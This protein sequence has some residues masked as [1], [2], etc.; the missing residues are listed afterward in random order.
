MAVFGGSA[1]WRRRGMKNGGDEGL[2][3]HE[4]GLQSGRSARP[5][6]DPVASTALERAEAD[7]L[8]D[9]VHSAQIS[10][11]MS[12]LSACRPLAVLVAAQEP[13]T[14]RHVVRL[15]GETHDAV[16]VGVVRDE[17]ATIDEVGRLR[18][19][20]VIVES[21]PP[22]CGGLRIAARL[23]Q[24]AGPD[25]IVVSGA[26]CYAAS[27]FDVAVLDYLL[28]PLR[29]DRLRRALHRARCRRTE[30]DSHR[31]ALLA[32]GAMRGDKTIHVPDRQ[33]GRNVCIGD[34]VWIQAERDY[35]LIHAVSRTHMLRTTMAA[36]AARLSPAIIRVHRSAFVSAR[37]VRRW[38]APAKG[39]HGLQLSN[40][41]E[42]VVGPTY[43]AAVRLALRSLDR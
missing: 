12:R 42:V 43:I 20:V 17:G 36:L 8:D 2:A 9:A 4:C 15:I 7:L 26:G 31:I 14:A 34:I 11:L 24:G 35:A 21:E 1:W 25:V 13:S 37:H 38:K 23:D 3:S 27:A 16:V 18:P 40:G 5:I 32:S 41:S 22:E 29:H 10:R 39:V 28:K 6:A 19:D 30:R 33:G